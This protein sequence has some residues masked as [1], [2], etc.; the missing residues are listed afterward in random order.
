M[1]CHIEPRVFLQRNACQKG[2][3]SP[4]RIK[5]ILFP[6]KLQIF[7]RILFSENGWRHDHYM[8]ITVKK[9]RKGH[10]YPKLGYGQWAR[11]RDC[12][13]T[14]LEETW[15]S[16]CGILW[17]CARQS[18]QLSTWHLWE[19]CSFGL[20]VKY[21]VSVCLVIGNIGFLFPDDSRLAI[22]LLADLCFFS[23]SLPWVVLGRPVIFFMCKVISPKG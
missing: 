23:I 21:C 6:Y 3:C 5:N 16:E 18:H 4:F 22:S 9:P 11:G 10:L 12:R 15:Y 14:G 19:T 2:L 7:S 8:Q 17:G 20:N 13:K 1:H